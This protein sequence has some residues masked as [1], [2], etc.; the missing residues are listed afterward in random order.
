[1]THMKSAGGNTAEPVIGGRYLT[2]GFVTQK[3]NIVTVVGLRG[4]A[5]HR[6]VRVEREDGMSVSVAI[7][8]F[9]ATYTKAGE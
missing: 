8:T 2:T 9:N 3:A 6:M 4:P 5:T 1:M 7:D